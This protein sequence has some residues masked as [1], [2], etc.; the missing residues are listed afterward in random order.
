[1]TNLIKNS[2]TSLVSSVALIALVSG[3]ASPSAS[4]KQTG[5]PAVR[6]VTLTGSVN[7]LNVLQAVADSGLA[8]GLPE[9][10]SKD[11]GAGVVEFGQYQFPDGLISAQVAILPGQKL[12][13][14]VKDSPEAEKTADLLRAKIEEKLK[15]VAQNSVA[16]GNS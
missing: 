15:S 11:T 1:M 7:N 3:C 10:T 4:N 2:L 16:P 14:T 13:I 12:Q 8:A 6:V 9:V 5:A